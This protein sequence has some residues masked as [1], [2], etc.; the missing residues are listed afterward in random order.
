MQVDPNLAQIL[1]RMVSPDFNQRYPSASDALLTVRS[2]KLGSTLLD[3]KTIIGAGSLFLFIS[4]TGYYYWQLENSLN[5]TSEESMFE[6]DQ[7]QFPFL[8]RNDVNGISMKYPSSWKVQSSQNQGTIAQLTPQED[9]SY[10][11]SPEISIEVERSN[12]ESLDK[13]TTNAVYQI[14]Q[15]PQVKVIDSRPTPFAG[16]NGHKIIF[17]TVNPDNNLEHKFLQ[18]WTLK[19]HRA[20]KVTYQATTNDYPKFAKTVQQ[21]MIGS[22]KINP[23]Q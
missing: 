6:E 14:T 15:L 11:V 19:D 12:A 20:Y 22:I 3:I 17:T 2:L 18:L 16:E 21:E 10:I 1:D 9:Q 7:T 13:Y 5:R 4:G 23:P 8:Y